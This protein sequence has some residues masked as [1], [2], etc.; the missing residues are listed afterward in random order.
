M[1]DRRASGNMAKQ[2]QKEF[3]D[4][5]MGIRCFKGMFSLKVEPDNKPYQ[6]SMKC[7]AYA[8]R[9]LFKEELEIFK[10]KTS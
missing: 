6:V 8:L 4:V 3:E 2:I 9:K 7:V 10:D 5:F 1:Y